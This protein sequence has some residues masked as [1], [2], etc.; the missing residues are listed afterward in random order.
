MFK[1]NIKIKIIFTILFI[2]IYSF[3]F[4]INLNDKNV[5][6]NKELVKISNRLQN[7]F[8]AIEDDIS[9]EVA[10]NSSIVNQD[11][12]VIGS[13]SGSIDKDGII[14]S[15]SFTNDG[16]SINILRTPTT[17]LSQKTSEKQA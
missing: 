2:I 12:I 5:E 1:K 17:S 8:H 4:D 9:V 14:N 11:E 7:S 16:G 10:S 13:V 6:I 3:I 15:G